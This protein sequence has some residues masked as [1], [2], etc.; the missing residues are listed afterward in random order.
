MKIFRKIDSCFIEK[1]L[2]P[3]KDSTVF[4][5]CGKTSYTKCGASAIFDFALEKLHINVVK[6]C[7]FCNNPKLENVLCALEIFAKAKPRIILAVGGGSAIDI[8][9]LVRY[10]AQ[11]KGIISA[12]PLFCFPT[13]AGSGA[14]ATHFA[15]LYINGTKHSVSSPTIKAERVFIDSR[16]CLTTSSYTRAASGLDALCHAIESYWSPRS[17]SHSRSYARKALLLIKKNLLCFIK[18][19]SLSSAKALSQAAYF[20]GRAIDITTT[21]ACHA[22]SYKITDLLK[23]PHGHA[24]AVS[25]PY[26]MKINAQITIKNCTDKKH[27]SAIK[28]N[29]A[30]LHRLLNLSSN[31]MA[32]F[33]KNCTKDLYK[34]AIPT[35]SQW[36][37]II[38]EP[39]SERLKNNPVLLQSLP[40][41]SDFIW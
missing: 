14:E 35:Q 13:T 3:Y 29:I 18:T 36:Q 17:T 1:L 15:V 30:K 2:F 27:F 6:F 22:F 26:F 11:K 25:L 20:A 24:V 5:V 21:T 38:T 31:D 12:L 23:L 8:A 39:N 28:H 33:I 9:K 16:F 40:A 10:Y 34:K 32:R 41:I 19:P 7:D 37:Q 4:L